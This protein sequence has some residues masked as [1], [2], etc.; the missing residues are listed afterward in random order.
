MNVTSG[1]IL[2][3][4]VTLSR[5][6][7]SG[8]W[9]PD[10]IQIWDAQGN[11][12]H[13][14]QTDYGWKLYI[15]NPLSDCEPPIYVKNSMTLSLSKTTTSDGKPYQIV[16][17]SW[18]VIE[19]TGIEFVYAVLNDDLRETHS[20]YRQS[21]YGGYDSESDRVVVKFKFPEY[22]PSGIYSLNHIRMSDL[23]LNVSSVYFT[24]DHVDEE[25]KTIE[26]KTKTP[27]LEPPVLDVNRIT[28]KAEPTIPEAPNGET[29]VDISFRIKDNISGY[30]VSSLNLR[31]PQ[32]VMHHFYH[33]PDGYGGLYFAGNPALFKEYHKRIVLPVG[34]VPGIWGLAEMTVFDKAGNALKSDFTEVVRF[35]VNDAPI[36]THSD[37][38]QDGTVNIQD[39][40]LV[41]NE[42][43]HPGPQ[44]AGVNADINADG[45]VNILDLVQIANNF[46]GGAPA[47]PTANPPTVE[48]IQSWIKQARQADDGSPAFR[49]GINVLETLL[50]SV[51]PE[52]TALLPNYPNP[53]NPE[54]WVPYQLA[55]ESDVKITIY[56]TRGMLVR[57][58]LLGYQSAGYYTNRSRA[59]YWDGRNNLGESVASGVYFYQ[60]QTD[61]TSLMRKMV[62]LK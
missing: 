19:K 28:I 53:F 47:A 15:D 30:E 25:P 57:T 4:Q 5:Y 51:R 21:E 6:A 23:A 9:A 17:A 24:E 40:V 20:I 62:I 38:N 22:M 8:Y 55:S 32:G 43:G 29:I 61:K 33:N 59:V 18:E 27:D 13:S 12:R 48:Q 41:A 16:T 31:D 60:L 54:T 7:A 26:I 56:D 34:S 46:G 36:Y 14:G 44:D 50:R 58:L 3:K 1:H 49:R 45:A 52:T 39:L 2:R 35:E 37:V 11:E 42:I 10:A